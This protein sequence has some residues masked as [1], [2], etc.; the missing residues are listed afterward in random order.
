[1]SLFDGVE[2]ITIT[3]NAVGAPVTGVTFDSFTFSPDP[4]HANTFIGI[5]TDKEVIEKK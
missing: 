3:F 5:P 4:K 2:Y 1:M